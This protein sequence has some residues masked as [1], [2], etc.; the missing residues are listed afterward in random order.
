MLGSP[1]VDLADI[2]T[3]GSAEFSPLRIYR[4]AVGLTQEELAERAECGRRTVVR[5]RARRYHADAADRASTRDRSRCVPADKLFPPS[6][7]HREAD[8]S[9]T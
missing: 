7:G 9:R 6:D 8:E 3:T 4:T 1:S 5:F 2:F